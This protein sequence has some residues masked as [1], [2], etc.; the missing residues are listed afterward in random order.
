M[1]TLAIKH[2]FKKIEKKEILHITLAREE[3]YLFI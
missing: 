3:I 2:A 1:L